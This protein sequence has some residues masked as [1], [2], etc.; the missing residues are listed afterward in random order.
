MKKSSLIAIVFGVLI[1]AAL[2]YNTLG[3]SQFH[4]ETCITYN[5]HTRCRTASARTKE[6]AQRAAAELACS[7]LEGSTADRIRCPNTLPDSVK[8]K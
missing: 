7:E 1:V 6:T 5:G 3:Q 2:I 4:C 8:W